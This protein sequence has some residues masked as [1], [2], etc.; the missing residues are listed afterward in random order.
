MKERYF[1][2]EYDK[3]TLRDIVLEKQEE[4]ERLNNIINELNEEVEIIKEDKKIEKLEINDNGLLIESP[5]VIEV[6]NKIN[7]IIDKINDKSEDNDK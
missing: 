2:L 4:I 6:V 5:S 3:E 7:E 1:S